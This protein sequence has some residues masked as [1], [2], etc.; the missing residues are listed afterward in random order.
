VTSSERRVQR[1]RKALD[2]PGEARDDIAILCE[3]A[4]RAGQDWGR[5]S[6]EAVW[7]E[8]R[9]LSPWHGGMSYARLEELNGLQWPCPDETHPGSPLLHDRL[10][11]DPIEGPR[12]PFMPVEFSP[13][14]DA[15]SPDFPIRL[16]TGRRLESFNTG[17]QTGG[18]RSPLH[19]G[20]SLDL[21]R[22]DA[23]RLGVSD[24]EVVRV[25]SRRG[26]VEAPVR[27]DD[28]LRP[29]LAFMTMHFPDEVETNVLT[30]DAWDRQSG[31][32]EFKAAAIRVE[33]L[34]VRAGA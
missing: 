14:I 19:R 27:L 16:T 21:C 25:V 9:S 11:K 34:G 15:L 26:A 12:A 30:N 28:S 22:D 31:T 6:A 8:V 7:D 3:L 29:G 10:W 23:A 33:K 20:E 13:Q 18:Y 5:P 2:P 1:V 17:V 32:A 24:G 4:R